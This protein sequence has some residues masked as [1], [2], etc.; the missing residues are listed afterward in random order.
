MC[1]SCRHGS[2]LSRNFRWVCF[3][4]HMLLGFKDFE[5]DQWFQPHL[6]QR[7]ISHLIQWE[8]ISNSYWWMNE[9]KKSLFSFWKKSQRKR[10]SWEQVSLEMGG[11]K[12]K[13]SK[14]E[15]IEKRR[16]LEIVGLEDRF[17]L[18]FIFPLENQP[19]AL[20]SWYFLP[21]MCPCALERGGLLSFCCKVHTGLTLSL[22]QPG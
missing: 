2:A 8:L 16:K 9:W 5:T 20:P 21:C 11:K 7:N 10:K 19:M 1:S 3:I 18:L 14:G 13:K 12:N 22:L 4:H 15:G 17:Y 6:Q